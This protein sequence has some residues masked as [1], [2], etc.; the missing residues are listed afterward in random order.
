MRQIESMHWSLY[1]LPSH[2]ASLY[3]LPL[4]EMIRNVQMMPLDS[5]LSAQL[6]GT[7][8]FDMTDMTTLLECNRAQVRVNM[9]SVFSILYIDHFIKNARQIGQTAESF[10][11]SLTDECVIDLQVVSTHLGSSSPVSDDVRPS[12]PL[13]VESSDVDLPPIEEMDKYV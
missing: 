4:I 8:I 13:S 7:M 3:T 1:A 10:V 6:Q 12:S 11:K 5:S 2:S 9:S